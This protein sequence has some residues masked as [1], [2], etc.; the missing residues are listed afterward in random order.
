MRDLRGARSPYGDDRGLRDLHQEHQGVA[1]V[2][3]RPPEA[4]N[5][6]QGRSDKPKHERHERREHLSGGRRSVP[7]AG[8][9][10]DP[11]PA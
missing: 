11:K 4:V 7:E 5:Q 3:K 10:S 8:D 1:S 9:R 2:P 6:K